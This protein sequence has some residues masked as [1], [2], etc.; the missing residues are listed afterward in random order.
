MNIIKQLILNR[1]PKDV[2]NG[3]LVCAK[4]IMIDDTASYITNEVGMSIGFECSNDGEFIVGCIPCNMELVIFTYN[5][6]TKESKIY[7]KNDTNNTLKELNTS[8]KYNGGE[9]TGTYTYNYK[10]ELIIVVGEYNA[11][12]IYD[13]D[14]YIPLKS[15]NLDNE[16]NNL[17]NNIE[18]I[19]PKYKSSYDVSNS[20]SLVCGVYT[21][22]IRFKINDETYTK[23]FQLTDDIIIINEIY[24]EPPYHTFSFNQEKVTADT[25]DFK[26]FKINDNNISNKSININLKWLES[27]IFTEFQIGYIIKRD[28]EVLGRIDNN[29]NINTTTF[30][31]SNNNYSKEIKIDNFL[32]SP[33]Q[34]YNVKNIINYNNR[35]YLSNYTEYKVEDL[36]EYADKVQASFISKAIQYKNSTN[37]FSLKATATLSL[38]QPAFTNT[39]FNIATY[40]KDNKRFIVNPHDFIKRLYADEIVI[41][42]DTEHLKMNK[43]NVF[44]NVDDRIDTIKTEYS[45]WVVNKNNAIDDRICI[46]YLD[47]NYPYEIQ[48]NDDNSVTIIDKSNKKEYKIGDSNIRFAIGIH[49]N[50]KYKDSDNYIGSY[51]FLGL[52]PKYNTPYGYPSDIS[53]FAGTIQIEK[54]ESIIVKNINTMFNNNRT[55]IPHQL[56]NFY[57][58]YIRKDKS[59][60]NGYRIQNVFDNNGLHFDIENIN[61]INYFK[62]PN[63]KNLDFPLQHPIFKNIDIPKDYIGWFISYEQVEQVTTGVIAVNVDKNEIT[64]TPF[65]YRGVPIIGDTSIGTFTK[66][67]A[68]KFNTKHKKDNKLREPYI[69]ISPYTVGDLII[70]SVIFKSN[71]LYNKEHKTLYRLT[72]DSFG[73]ESDIT[74]SYKYCPGFYNQEKIVTYDKEIIANPTVSQVS[75]A[76]GAPTK[77]KISI[78]TAYNYNI[79]PLAAY[80]IKQDYNKGAVSL[81]DANNRPLGS[82]FNSVLSPDRVRDFLEIKPAYIAKPNKTYT[83][84]NKNHIDT[85]NKTIYRSNIISDE[86]LKNNFREFKIN[87]YKNIFENKGN[88]VNIVGIGLYFIVHTEYSIFVFDRTAKLTNKTQLDIP[89]TFDTFYTELLPSNEGFGGLQDKDESI[90]TKHGYIWFDKINKL[91]FSYENGKIEV[92]SKDINNLLKSLNINKVTFVE[93][94]IYNRLLICIRLNQKYNKDDIDVASITL[95]YNFNTKTFIS[96]HDYSFTNNYRTY[97]NSYLFDKYKDRKRLYIFDK[98]SNTYGNLINK[99]SLFY[100]KYNI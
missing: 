45:L 43:L 76:D 7:R 56:Y 36:T 75:D 61:G 58:H 86:S 98:H 3:S 87:N 2:P 50:I 72:D 15:W 14:L 9:I 70:S 30:S 27:T 41:D 23:W 59:Y 20:G 37:N 39:L 31:L 4:N 66:H 55:L 8:W 94:I 49:I 89:D 1:N 11:K 13:D 5:S 100:P 33:H 54:K 68:V 47:Y 29:Y 77:Y 60:T 97:N 38:K 25:S 90:I 44:H 85:F 64:N 21:I 96:L 16:N 42:T 71:S 69:K 28:A 83:N 48:I 65:I 78:I 35:V 91:I 40:I 18:E 79:E 73:N 62:L 10:K 52:N 63:S 95:S 81:F 26:E 67:H 53:V 12:N 22:F 17:T 88:I 34:F 51:G 92:I 82:Y 32:E 84:Y 6:I 93:D 57:I 99:H 46:F 74:Q 80:S 24:K 19:I